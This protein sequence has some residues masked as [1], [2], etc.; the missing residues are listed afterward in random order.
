M[1]EARAA[2]HFSRHA[3]INDLKFHP[4]ECFNTSSLVHAARMGS[5]LAPYTDNDWIASFK[6]LA[7]QSAMRGKSICLEGRVRFES[8]L[9]DPVTQACIV[10]SSSRLSY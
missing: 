6:R 3:W 5:C 8:V 2:A 10:G 4:W 1:S 9:T 7:C